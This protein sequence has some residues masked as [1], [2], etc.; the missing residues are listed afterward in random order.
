MTRA[1][2]VTIKGLLSA[3]CASAT[4]AVTMFLQFEWTDGEIAIYIAVWL[5]GTQR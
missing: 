2:E 1:T 4:I 3:I 5:L